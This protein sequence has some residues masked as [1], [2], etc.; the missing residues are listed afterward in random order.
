ML[1][2]HMTQRRLQI[3]DVSSVTITGVLVTTLAPDLN[4]A[5]AR[6]S[7]SFGFTTV[8]SPA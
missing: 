4:S 3:D 6:T 5:R 1:C 2:G 8:L 7:L